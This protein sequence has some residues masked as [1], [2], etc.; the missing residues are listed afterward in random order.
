[1]V[2]SVSGHPRVE[3]ERD[4][5]R[6]FDKSPLLRT[7]VDEIEEPAQPTSIV[8]GYLDADLD[9]CSK[10]RTLN[11]SELK[12]VS[13]KILQAL[14]TFMIGDIV[15]PVPISNAH[16][17]TF[18]TDCTSNIRLMNIL[19]NFPRNTS[20]NRFS[21][22]KVADFGETYRIDSEQAKNWLPISASIWRSPEAQMQ[23][24]NGWNAATDN[25]SFGLCVS[26]PYSNVPTW[27][28]AR[29]TD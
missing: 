21:D 23:I 26:Y 14:D 8:L 29:S 22:V 25:W 2:K 1:M 6:L 28:F 24:N 4:I 11:R 5:L 10:E 18:L 13:K 12:Y 27:D 3:H 16:L 20:S 17:V 9:Q 7:L 19:I 15:I